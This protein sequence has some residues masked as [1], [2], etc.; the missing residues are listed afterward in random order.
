MSEETK[1]KIGLA[2][3]IALKG[4]PS[5]FRGMKFPE[6]QRENNYNWK[7]GKPH[8]LDCGVTIWYTSKRCNKCAQIEKIK[9]PE[10]HRKLSE[11]LK[12]VNT[13]NSARKVSLE[14][15]RKMSV[16]HIGEKCHLWRGGVT[17]E[18]HKVRSSLEMKIWR[19]AVFERDNYTCQGCGI[20][21][22]KGV[23]GRVYLCADHIKPFALYP[24]LRFAIDNGRTLCKACH[25][26]TDT[27][28]HKTKVLRERMELE[29]TI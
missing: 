20:R 27:Y 4:R 16:A 1:R 10:Y 25:L 13:W 24:E 21:T 22:L 29:Q 26:K 8:C 14:T 18:N 9:D 12:G 7:G 3:S 15:R 11:S 6:R 19:R 23:T 28:G 2:N 5:P 17:P